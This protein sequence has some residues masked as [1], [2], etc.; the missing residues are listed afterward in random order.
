MYIIIRAPACRAGDSIY[1][2]NI[3]ITFDSAKF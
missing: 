1:A 3:L 2:A